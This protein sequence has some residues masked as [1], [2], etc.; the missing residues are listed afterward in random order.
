MENTTLHNPGEIQRLG[1]NIGDKI[2]IVR[3]GDVI[4][5]I[6]R[7]LGRA[8][9]SD[10]E[11]R[12]HADGTPF[13][14]KL[15]PSKAIEIPAKCPAC[16]SD[17]QVE[18]AFIKCYNT[19]CSAR[20][21]RAVLYWCRALEMDGIGEKLVEQ[22]FE[23]S[24]ISSIADLYQLDLAGLM[25]LERMGNKSAKNVLFELNRTKQMSLG[26]FIHALGLSGIGP[27]LATS[28]AS[29]V[30]TL[31]GLLDWLYRAHT[32]REDA[33]FGPLFDDSGKP[34]KENSAIRE[35]CQH[36]G[37]GE[38][39]AHQI[40]N[41]LEQRKS[42]IINLSQYLILTEEPI[43]A[44]AGKFDGMT[45]CITGTLSQPRK[46]VQ[47]MIKS[48]G[49]KVVGSISAKLDI[50]ITG[51]NAGSKLAKAERLGITVWSEALFNNAVETG[52]QLLEGAH[53]DDGRT[54]NQAQ[55]S[56]LDF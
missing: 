20:T 55:K 41:G 16:K 8:T 39:V 9:H 17:L 33:D 30:K 24:M 14:A 36:D 53:S 56:L 46:A 21:S 49:G 1:V 32:T 44:S 27:E 25:S 54:P 50:L 51:D 28:F 18:G 22:L 29:H 5:K 43:S 38:K 34:H 37:I 52:T 10:L 42:L 26:K 7:T 45:F 23:S 40:R 4:P 12:R 15:P 47:M 3:R 48:L 19:L 2:L 6:E 31:D 35:I 13:S 11:H